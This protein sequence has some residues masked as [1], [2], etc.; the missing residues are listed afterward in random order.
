VRAHLVDGLQ[1]GEAASKLARGED[2]LL[3]QLPVER[4]VRVQVVRTKHPR[5]A[6]LS[7][8]ALFQAGKHLRL[9]D[10]GHAH[11]LVR[12]LAEVLLDAPPG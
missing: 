12:E 3:V 6:V 9:V 8:A 11:E 10:G 7:A 5:L 1:M 2:V 4:A